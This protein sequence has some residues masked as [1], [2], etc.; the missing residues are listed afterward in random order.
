MF[1][2]QFTKKNVNQA[3]KFLKGSEKKEPS[4]LKKFKGVVKN[5]L[6][7]LDDKRVIPK[8]EVEEFLRKKVLGGKVPF[9]RDGLY[10]YLIKAGFAGV[11]RAQIDNFLKKQKIIRKTDKLQPV[12][13]RTKRKV[14]RKGQICYDLIEINWKDLGF[15]P[16]EMIAWEKKQKKDPDYDP[17]DPQGKKRLKLPR[18]AAYMFSAVDKLSGLMFVKFSFTKARKYVTPIAEKCFKFFAKSFEIPMTKI[19][20]FSDKGKEF[21]FEK[22]NSWGVR[23]KQVRREPLI[24]NK[25]AQ[26]QSALYRVAK[27]NLS[28]SIEDLID[29]AVQVVNRTKSRL[30][31]LARVEAISA[32]ESELSLNCNKRRG[33][34]SGMK[35]KARKLKIGDTVRLNLIGPKKDSFYKAYKGKQ[36]S[37]KRYKILQKKGNRYKIEIDGK[38]QFFHRD[39]L[40]ITPPSDMTT[41]KILYKRGKKLNK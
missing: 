27:M 36:Y 31:K 32:P 22:Y 2:Y 35:V 41:E 40:R 34:E 16:K 7:Y 26:F 28:K 24:E 8:E 17:S 13:K 1:R 20:A 21:D 30:L 18:P 25:N 37:D 15:K 14:N 10:Y 6:L 33:K 39:D 23:T 38:K 11:K 9:S 5:G 29:R 12:T 3:I 19:V 4:F